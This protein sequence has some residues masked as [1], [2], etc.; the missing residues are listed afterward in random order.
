MKFLSGQDEFRRG[1]DEFR[2]GQDDFFQNANQPISV[3]HFSLPYNNYIS[4]MAETNRTRLISTSLI[5]SEARTL[6]TQTQTRTL[7][8]NI[9]CSI[10]FSCTSFIGRVWKVA[11]ASCVFGGIGTILNLDKKLIKSQSKSYRRKLEFPEIGSNEFNVLPEELQTKVR[12]LSYLPNDDED[13]VSWLKSF[14]LNNS[15]N[16]RK[17]GP[18]MITSK[19]LTFVYGFLHMMLDQMGKIAIEILDQTARNTQ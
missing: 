11:L 3:R 19:P 8:V 6:G 17:L 7:T 2:R 12:G 15:Y 10:C 4:F 5:S 18:F 9:V 16:I 13:F 1:Q 14:D